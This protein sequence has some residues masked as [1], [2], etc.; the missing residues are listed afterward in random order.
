MIGQGETTYRCGLS[1]GR[2]LRV[3]GMCLPAVE[4]RGCRDSLNLFQH[5]GHDGIWVD[6]KTRFSI[7]CS[8]SW[9]CHSVCTEATINPFSLI[10]ARYGQ[11]VFHSTVNTDKYRGAARPPATTHSILLM[12]HLELRAC[13]AQIQ[14]IDMNQL[15]FI[16]LWRYW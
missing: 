11:L 12:S 15:S 2:G 10:I 13:A 9:C 1:R 8:L 5:Q 16:R 14:Q 3:R 6:S 7:E 4:A